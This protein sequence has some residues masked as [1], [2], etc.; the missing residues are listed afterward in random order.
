M[1]STLCRRLRSNPTTANSR[2]VVLS[3]SLS[4]E[5]IAAARVAG[6]DAWI[7]KGASRS[8]ILRISGFGGELNEQ[9]APQYGAGTINQ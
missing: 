8:E 5:K 2:L 3:G 9:R 4:D 6:A 7:E 1:E